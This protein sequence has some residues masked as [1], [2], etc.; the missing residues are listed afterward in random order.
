L[1]IGGEMGRERIPTSN[2]PS[3]NEPLEM[4]SEAVLVLPD[5]EA[6]F[7]HAEFLSRVLEL[8]EAWNVKDCILAGD[9]LHLD[10]FSSFNKPWVKAQN[11][12]L[13]EAS[14]K[15]LMSFAQT[16]GSKQ[17]GRMMEMIGDMGRREETDG[18]STELKEAG[19][20]LARLADQFDN[21]D[22]ILGNHEGRTLRIF[23]TALTP[24]ILLD[25]VHIPDGQRARWRIAPY[26]FSILHS[27]GRK[28]Q[29]EHPSSLGPGSAVN[30]CAQFHCDILHAHD[31]ELSFQF[32]LSGNY[33]A[34]Q[35]GHAV[36]ES[37]LAYAAQRHRRKRAT[38]SL[39]AV[40]VR[41]GF[42]WLLHKY[43]PFDKLAMI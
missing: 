34:I 25:L 28:F 14:E 18:A 8:A 42:P 27:G 24:N 12:S 30:L 31:H 2:Y 23:E 11:G 40:I 29:V 33:Y 13:D 22:L 21:V 9:A 3:Y 19:K 32:D 16:L 10:T 37:R 26:Y 4:T 7:H 39:G 43:T 38:H 36:D 17:Q 35:M 15:T 6:P 5:V 20:V 41:N 1:L